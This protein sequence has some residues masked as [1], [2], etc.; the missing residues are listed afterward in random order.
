MEIIEI[1]IEYAG[2][3]KIFDKATWSKETGEVLVSERLKQIVRE[4]AAV[5]SRLLDI[6]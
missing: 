3:L 2:G 5:V 4:V 1:E 6:D